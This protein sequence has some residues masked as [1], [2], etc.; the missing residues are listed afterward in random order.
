M[1]TIECF[2]LLVEDR[3]GGY[4]SQHTLS[5]E[6]LSRTPA[7]GVALF[8]RRCSKRREAVPTGPHFC[9]PLPSADLDGHRLFQPKVPSA[10]PSV[11]STFV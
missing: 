1:D 5:Q 8:F 2:A 11:P 6:G 9:R 3:R 10:G 4:W 7:Y